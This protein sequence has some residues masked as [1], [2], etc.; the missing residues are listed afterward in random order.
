MQV[1]LPSNVS[2]FL[3]NTVNALKAELSGGGEGLV[4]T[5]TWHLSGAHPWNS[6]QDTQF[7][8]TNPQSYSCQSQ[9]LG[10]LTWFYDDREQKYFIEF[11][12]NL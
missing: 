12:F 10:H 2:W 8:S 11:H 5:D 6:M 9:Q 4:V 1:T 3:G 7:S